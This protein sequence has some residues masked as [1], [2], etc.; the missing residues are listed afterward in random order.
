MT[1]LI[2]ITIAATMITQMK[3]NVVES[4]YAPGDRLAMFT[5]Y[6]RQPK[7]EKWETTT[8]SKET[9]MSFEWLGQTRTVVD[10]TPISTNTVHLKIKENW[11]EVK[12]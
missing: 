11:E 12:P 8:I 9:S 2:T 4:N 3:T 10:S 5:Y 1:N 7:S 6:D